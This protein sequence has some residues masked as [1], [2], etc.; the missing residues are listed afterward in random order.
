MVSLDQPLP[1]SGM[2]QLE[3]KANLVAA[4]FPPWQGW[5]VYVDIDAMERCNGGIH[6]TGNLTAS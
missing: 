6:P 5:M 4:A 2:F 3:A 1:A